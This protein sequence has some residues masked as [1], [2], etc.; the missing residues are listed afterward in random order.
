MLPSLRRPLRIACLLAGSLAVAGSSVAQTTVAPEA[1]APAPAAN[2]AI[3]PPAMPAGVVPPAGYVIGPADVLSIVFWKEKDI[4]ADVTVRPDG[5]ISLSLIN[6]VP[7]AGLTPEQL[8]VAIT[9]RAGQFVTDPTVTVV[10][11]EINSRKV[12]I[13]GQVAKPGPYPLMA[14]TSVLQL[15]ALS[16]GV[17]EY[18]DSEN[19]TVVRTDN[20]KETPIRVNYK[21]I[22]RGKKLEQ[23]IQLKPGD[24]VIVP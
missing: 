19:V 3:K 9:E 22:M 11:K 17:A 12:F 13:V 2:T 4:S 23:N 18:A 15:I 6:E 10:V 16:G 5:V 8:R 24:T 21:E 14:P 20:G 1:V 7:A